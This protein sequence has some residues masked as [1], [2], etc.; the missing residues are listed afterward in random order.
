MHFLLVDLYLAWLVRATNRPTQIDLFSCFLFFLQI[1]DRVSVAFIRSQFVFVGWHRKTALLPPF[2]PKNTA[3]SSQ[4]SSHSGGHRELA[5]NGTGLYRVFPFFFA[6]NIF[7]LLA[8]GSPAEVGRNTRRATRP[9]QNGN[10]TRPPFPSWWRGWRFLSLSLSLC[11]SLCRVSQQRQTLPCRSVM[12]LRSIFIGVF[13]GKYTLVLPGSIEG[14]SAPA[15]TPSFTTSR[16]FCLFFFTGFFLWFYRVFTGSAPCFP[17]H[18]WL[19]VRI[20]VLLVGTWSFQIDFS[21][22]H[23]VLPL[24]G[25]DKYHYDYS[26]TSTRIV[27]F[28]WLRGFL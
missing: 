8:L 17:R 20:L 28:Y 5:L 22:F 18:L 6:S 1:D 4:C 25:T 9:M 19:T 7:F 12:S 3:S 21:V 10:A 13:I 15:P 27:T 26:I 24:W 2:G 11:F 16:G 23:S 14:C